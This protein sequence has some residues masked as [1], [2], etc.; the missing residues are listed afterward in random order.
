[1]SYGFYR[2]GNPNQVFAFFENE[3]HAVFIAKFINDHGGSYESAMRKAA[4]NA[5][6]NINA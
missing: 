1:M 6:D 5:W 3:D 4:R 2:P